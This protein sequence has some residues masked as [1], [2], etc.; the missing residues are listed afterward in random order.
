MKIRW[1]RPYSRAKDFHH[2][3]PD[4][5][6]CYVTEPTQYKTVVLEGHHPEGNVQ[7]TAVK[8]KHYVKID[9]WIVVISFKWIG[10]YKKK[11]MYD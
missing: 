6:V 2:M 8:Y 7:R 5:F 1:R 4:A 11:K 9:L 10:R 3:M